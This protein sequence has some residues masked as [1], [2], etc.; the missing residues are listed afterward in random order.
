MSCRNGTHPW[1]ELARTSDG[2]DVERVVRWCGMC[3]SVVIDAEIDG[4]I[5]PGHYMRIR[6]PAVVKDPRIQL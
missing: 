2:Y 3:G 4:R 1:V 5:D 6:V